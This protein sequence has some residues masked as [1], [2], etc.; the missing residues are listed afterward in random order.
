MGGIVSFAFIFLPWDIC[1][2]AECLQKSLT[3]YLT[4]LTREVIK[5]RGHVFGWVPIRGVADHQ[6]RFAH[7]SVA[8]QDALQQPLLRLPRPGRTGVVRRHRRGHGL[9]VIHGDLR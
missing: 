5:C 3:V 6:T 1:A 4:L 7:S 9:S 2:P 8:E